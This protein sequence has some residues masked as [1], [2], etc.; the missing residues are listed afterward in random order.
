MKC[1][2]LV[3]CS[4]AFSS[5]RP[6]PLVFPRRDRAARRHPPRLWT[7]GTSRRLW[8]PRFPLFRQ[9]REQPIGAIFRR[10]DPIVQQPAGERWTKPECW[11]WQPVR[12]SHNLWQLGPN[13]Q[14]HQQ[15]HQVKP[16]KEPIWLNFD[17]L[18]NSNCAQ[19]A[20]H[21][22]ERLREAG[23]QLQP[24]QQVGVKQRSSFD[25]F[26]EYIF[27]KPS[28]GTANHKNKI[29]QNQFGSKIVIRICFP[30]VVGGLQ[31]VFVQQRRGVQHTACLQLAVE[32]IQETVNPIYLFI[33]LFI[34][35]IATDDN[36]YCPRHISWRLYLFWKRPESTIRLAL[37]LIY[38]TT[39]EYGIW[40]LW[41]WW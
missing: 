37:N 4:Q 34:C 18:T 5:T 26:K 7:S 25:K 10:R 19:T 31:H 38:D 22:K 28:Y 14:Q 3:P 41:I 40:S 29:S 30:Q 23:G 21:W 8:R 9:L 2:T 13:V 20:K 6:P 15:H 12:A 16:L 32:E 24:W 11:G 17:Q 39:H 36:K 1:L 33:C 27:S 35:V